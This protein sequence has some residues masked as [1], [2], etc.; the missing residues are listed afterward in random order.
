[1]IHRHGLRPG[2]AGQWLRRVGY[3][4]WAIRPHRADDESARPAAETLTVVPF[5][6][7]PNVRGLQPPDP[8][9]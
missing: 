3:G 5:W 4:H 7:R 1:M 2:P 6:E 8:Q 9:R